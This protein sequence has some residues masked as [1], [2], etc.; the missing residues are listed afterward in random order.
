M[1]KETHTQM[2][3]KRMKPI[4]VQYQGDDVEN[5]ARLN[6]A[7]EIQLKMQRSSK[8]SSAVVVALHLEPELCFI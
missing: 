6:E 1:D 8:L 7:E 5:L 2:R 3:R 4:C